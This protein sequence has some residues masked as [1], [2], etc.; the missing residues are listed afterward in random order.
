MKLRYVADPGCAPARGN[1]FAAGIDLRAAGDYYVS[2]GS[3][4]NVRTGLRVEI[5]PGHVGLVRGRSGLAFNRSVLVFEGTIDEDYRGE[6]GVLMYCIDRHEGCS[7]G[8]GARV[9]QLVIVPVLHVELEEVDKLSETDRGESG[10]G[11]T[12]YR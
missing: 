10:Y 8:K 6:I 1:A 7:I 4:L 5:P 3:A 2:P 12:G 11:S 9:A